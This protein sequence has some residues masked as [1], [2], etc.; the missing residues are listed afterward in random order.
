MKNIGKLAVL[1]AV[2]AASA[3]YALAD[4]ISLASTGAA[5]LGGYQPATGGSNSAITYVGSQLFNSD[6]SPCG[7]G[8][9]FCLPAF[10]GLTALTGT[11][12]V[13]LAPFG[14]WAGP[15]G[16]TSSP[17]PG[18]NSSWVGINANAGPQLTSN[19][20]YGY[21]EYTSTFTA[22][23]GVYNGNL[24]IM[25]DDTA[26]IMINGTTIIPFGALGSDIDCGSGLPG[27]LQE[28]NLVINGLVLA[29]GVNTITIIDSQ[30]GTGPT[31]GINDPSG[32]DFD[33][34]LSLAATP[35]P[36]SLILL[37]TGLVGA[38]GL[39]FRRRQVV[40]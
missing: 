21:Y 3:S 34:G 23:G 8:V 19:P 38:A 12:A 29:A 2:L 37:G 39:L 25:A 35:E 17:V 28:D 5:G 31:G 18:P 16:S 1:G 33:G 15:L 30:A 14:V 24:D 26:E 36:S 40:A 27:C 11:A 20:Q 13:D 7:V 4:S 32:I 22:A 6:T 9:P 10:T